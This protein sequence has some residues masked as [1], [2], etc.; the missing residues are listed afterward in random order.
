MRGILF[1][2]EE[3]K[4]TI[5]NQKRKIER[6]KKQKLPNYEVVVGMAEYKIKE[7]ENV[8][9]KEQI[10]KHKMLNPDL[11]NLTET[12]TQA[13]KD[14]YLQYERLPPQ[15]KKHFENYVSYKNCIFLD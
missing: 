10:N 14:M 15:K 6:E 2:I 12:I 4:E 11:N 8:I 9:A 5:E 7:A 13:V 1:K 3:S